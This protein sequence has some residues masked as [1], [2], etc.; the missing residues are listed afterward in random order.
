MTPQSY[1]DPD[2]DADRLEARL[3]L[4]GT[5]T[6]SCRIAGCTEDDP[7]ALNG[8]YPDLLC[9]EH[10]A[11]HVN[12]SPVEASHTAGRANAPTDTV[13][14]PANDHAVLTHAHQAGWPSETLRNA[15][16]SPLLKAAAA[17]R[18]WLDVLR[19]I[20]ERTVGWVPGLLE[21]LDAWLRIRLGEQWWKEFPEGPA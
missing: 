17:T 6:P 1:I 15:D 5:R 14:L 16:G 13:D 21:Q 11:E 3:R 18:G 19:L 7:F 9:A 4:L 2:S 10:A 12:R 20:I 8:V